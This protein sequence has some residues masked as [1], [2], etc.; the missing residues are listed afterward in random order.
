MH[1]DRCILKLNAGS[2]AR[3]TFEFAPLVVRHCSPPTWTGYLALL[4]P[5]HLRYLVNDADFFHLHVHE[6]GCLA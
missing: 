3:K 2:G 1:C 5:I 4:T 6:E